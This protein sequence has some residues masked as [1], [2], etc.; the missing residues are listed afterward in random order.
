MS[1]TI[2]AYRSGRNRGRRQHYLQENHSTILPQRM[3]FFDTETSPSHEGEYQINHFRMGSAVYWERRDSVDYTKTDWISYDDIPLFWEWVFSHVHAKTVT[4]LVA[5]N[6]DFDFSV[7]KGFS[8]FHSRGFDLVFYM[9]DYNRFLLKYRKGS[10]VI[11][12][13]DNMNFF[14]MRLKKLGDIFKVPKYDMPCENATKEEWYRYCRND[15]KILLKVW[16]VW[17]DFL[18]SHDLGKLGYTLASQCFNAYRHRFMPQKI[19]VHTQPGIIELERES[20][21]G[22]RVE[23]YKVG[24]LSG[25]EYYYY[26]VNSMYPYVM[27][28]NL[29]PVN[30]VGSGYNLRLSTLEKQLEIRCITAQV[31]LKT[32]SPVYGVKW[33]GKLIFPVGEFETVLTTSELVY[34]LEHGHIQSI[35][36]YALYD[37]GDIFTSYVDYFYSLR[38]HYEAQG[39]EVY[40]FLMKR[41]LN[42]LY[43]RFGLKLED[44]EYLDRQEDVLFDSDTVYNYQTK[45]IIRYRVIDGKREIFRGW[46]EG[47]HSVVCIASEVT[48]NARM[49]LWDYQL[50]AGRENVVYC[51]TD[52]LI[53][54]TTGSERLKDSIDQTEL[55]K[56]KLEGMSDILILNN[57][58]DYVFGDNRKLKGVRENADRDENGNYVQWHSEGIKTRLRLQSPDRSRWKRVIKK[59]SPSYNKGD[60]KEG[61]IVLPLRLGESGD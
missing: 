51:D 33:K 44:W 46:K 31:K 54:N 38:K 43:G 35:G 32:D 47:Y 21:K 2:T 26:D 45:E 42:S 40:A 19:S 61:G 11:I 57:C 30:V 41:F 23:C 48:A 60:V 17:L 4:Y 18:R 14:P 39:N 6:V 15:T 58:K 24:N 5:H 10:S 22:G 28:S 37:K 29:Y 1:H 59:I 7:L 34:A 16:Q 50:K 3:I 36:R 8:E 52:S 9:L 20:Y 56:L 53:V 55:G 25:E 27:K 12:V 49:L 13:M